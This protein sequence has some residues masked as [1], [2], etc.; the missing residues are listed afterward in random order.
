[1]IE[2]ASSI[3]EILEDGSYVLHDGERKLILPANITPEQLTMESINF[4]PAY[5][6]DE[7]MISKLAGYL[8]PFGKV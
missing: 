8:W 6:K 5:N 1:M 2:G 3:V 7:G 4:F